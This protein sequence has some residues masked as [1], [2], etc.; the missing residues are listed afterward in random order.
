M[1]SWRK[2]IL[3]IVP[4]GLMVSLGLSYF[5]HPKL[6]V[7]AEKLVVGS[8]APKLNVEHWVQDGGGKFKKVT[9]FVPGKVYVW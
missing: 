7:S 9:S 1:F 3:A 8:V 6:A 5:H 2:L 4:I